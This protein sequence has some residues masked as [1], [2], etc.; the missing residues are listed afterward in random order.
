MS[1]FASYEP[2]SKQGAATTR[3]TLTGD[4]IMLG[5]NLMRKLI[6]LVVF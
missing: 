3:S 4:M 5:K 6:C 1:L 2:E